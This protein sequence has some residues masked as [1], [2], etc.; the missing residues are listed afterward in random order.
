[1]TAR[2]IFEHGR[3][4]VMEAPVDAPAA[5]PVKKPSTRP[6][7]S[8]PPPAPQRDP[9]PDNPFRRRARPAVMPRPKACETVERRAQQTVSKLLD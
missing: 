8:S 3:K 7:P 5:P 1:M 4:V 6:A 2:E 9:N